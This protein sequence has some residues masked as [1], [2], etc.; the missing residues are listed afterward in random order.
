MP[1]WPHLSNIGGEIQALRGQRVHQARKGQAIKHD[2]SCLQCP[3]E[4]RHH[5]HLRQARQCAEGFVG[6][7]PG[8]MHCGRVAICD[9]IHTPT[10]TCRAGFVIQAAGRNSLEG[11][12][13]T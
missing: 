1:V 4:G 13:P 5:H 11:R 9:T 12:L 7:T 3:C 8:A 6:C 2:V 10:F